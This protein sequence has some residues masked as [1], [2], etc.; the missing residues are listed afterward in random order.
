MEN[1]VYL[2]RAPDRITGFLRVGV[3]GHRQLETL[4]LSGRLPAERLV[5]DASAFARQGD[6]VG[7]LKAAG[8]ELSLDTNVAEL[9]S[10][11]RYQGAARTAP[12]ANPDRVIGPS[13]L[14][15]NERLVLAQIAQFAVTNGLHRVQ[16][17]THFL[18]DG[19]N[20]PWFR[21]DLE[22]C[23]RLRRLLDMEGG[24]DIAIDY[25]LMITN[26]TLNDT[27]ERAAIVPA[28]VNLPIQSVWLR[29]SGFGADATPAGVG[30]YIV[31]LRDFSSLHLPVVSD[32]VGGMAG[33][34]VTAFGA[35]SG[36]AHGVAEKERFDARSWSKPRPEGGGGGGGYTVLLP[37]I[38][39]LLKKEEAQTLMAAPHARRM[40]SCQDQGCCPGGFED[41]LRDPKGH[42]LRQ[43]KIQCDA[44]S[45]VQDQ[46][47]A[48]HFLDKTLAGASKTARQAS[49][50]KTGHEGLGTALVKNARRLERMGEVLEN[51]HEIEE[52]VA[53]VPAF[54]AI[55]PQG[56]SRVQGERE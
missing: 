42:Y 51:L 50:L 34:A 37:G 45:A 27:A 16:A 53:R 5:L 23:V 29:T 17:P 47:R 33:L 31:A 4:L 8:R 38:D 10:V 12:W 44:L 3:S 52:G 18:E 24:K 39:R 6:L 25:P 19:A 13:D 21:I 36:L 20:D 40:L 49:K 55:R 35:A 2:R 22:V 14:L 32:S 9:S 46:L 43:R 28:L 1:V 7:A 54:A 30:K 15:G 48:H 41:T 11:G 56:N 26:S